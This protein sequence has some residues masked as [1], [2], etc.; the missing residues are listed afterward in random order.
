MRESHKEAFHAYPDGS[1]LF[2]RRK[3]TTAG[4]GLVVFRFGDVPE[5]GGVPIVSACGPVNVD[6]K[7]SMFLGAER[8]TNHTAELSAVAEFLLWLMPTS[9]ALSLASRM[10]R[11]ALHSD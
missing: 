11:V 2:K 1:C 10:D 4:W 8:W 3:A 5:N 7:S 9:K 6:S